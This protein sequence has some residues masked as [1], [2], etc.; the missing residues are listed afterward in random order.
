VILQESK[1]VPIAEADWTDDGEVELLTFPDADG[2]T[3]MAPETARALAQQLIDAATEAEK[4]AGESVV[5]RAERATEH[6]FDV[7][8]RP[9]RLRPCVEAW[10]EAASGEYDPR[11][12]RFPKSCS[13]TV[14]DSTR[15][16]DEDLEE[17]S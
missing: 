5:Q 14:Y 15:V 2:R 8:Q 10:P 7:D 13:A 3:R 17:R 12:C 11:C 16:R 4:A 6:G 9:R 1:T